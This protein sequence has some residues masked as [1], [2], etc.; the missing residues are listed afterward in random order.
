MF[1][2]SDIVKLTS[3]RRHK[4]R[5]VVRCAAGTKLAKLDALHGTI[6]AKLM[7]TGEAFWVVHGAKPRKGLAGEPSNVNSPSV[8]RIW[9]GRKAHW[10]KGWWRTECL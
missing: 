7:A 3:N 10:C 9:L 1:T 8:E 5:I 6:E 4:R 2:S